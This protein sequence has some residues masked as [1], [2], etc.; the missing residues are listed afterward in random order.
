MSAYAGWSNYETWAIKRWLDND[1]GA[2]LRVQEMARAAIRNA[3]RR[4]SVMPARTYAPDGLLTIK[5][6]EVCLLA[7]ALESMHD[8]AVFYLDGV[9]SDLLSYTLERV[10]WCEIAKSILDDAREMEPR[11]RP[12]RFGV[13]RM[14]AHD[15]WTRLDNDPLTRTYRFRSLAAVERWYRE[16]ADSTHD[17]TGG[18]PT[19]ALVWAR[20]SDDYRVDTADYPEYVLAI[21]PRGGVVRTAA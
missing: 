16:L 14:S 4:R 9:L 1:E 8:D 12:A 19:H 21:G 3:P 18:W 5:N 10:D 17:V 13:E 15:F 6:A 2:Y 7:D 20:V 11:R